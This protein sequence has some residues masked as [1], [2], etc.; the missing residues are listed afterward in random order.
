MQTGEDY[1]N[2][3]VNSYLASLCHNN[4]LN[5]NRSGH[6]VTHSQYYMLTSSLAPIFKQQGSEGFILIFAIVVKHIAFKVIRHLWLISASLSYTG[7]PVH[8]FYM[9]S[10]AQLVQ[11]AHI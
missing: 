5:N 1:S 11:D 6:G 2:T 10:S 7:L 8:S 9:T 4:N 3:T